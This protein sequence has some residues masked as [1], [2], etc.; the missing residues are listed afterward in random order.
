MKRTM[1]ED[2]LTLFKGL[3]GVVGVSGVVMPMMARIRRFSSS[4]VATSERN[5]STNA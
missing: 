5:L 2:V 4:K 3:I 1:K